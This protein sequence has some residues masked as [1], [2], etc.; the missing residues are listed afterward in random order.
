MLIARALVK[1]PPLLIL[2]E[3]Q[4]GLDPLNRHLVRE[5]VARTAWAREPELLFVSHHADD[6]PPGLTHRLSFV[7]REGG[8]DY[9]QER[10]GS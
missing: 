7:P 2:D 4:Q 10:L 1:H 3:P 5:M 6:A 9:L 8:Y